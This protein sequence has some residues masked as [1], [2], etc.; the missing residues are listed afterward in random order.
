MILALRNYAPMFS[1]NR[2]YS[3]LDS[4]SVGIRVLLPSHAHS[5]LSCRCGYRQHLGTMT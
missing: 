3:S 4:S 2:Q 1:Q 5:T